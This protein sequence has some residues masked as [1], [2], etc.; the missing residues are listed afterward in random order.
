[1][2]AVESGPTSQADPIDRYIDTVQA[3]LEHVR[4]QK[5][6]IGRAAEACAESIARDG[7]AFS[8]GTGHGSFA[9]LEMF[10]RTG[11]IV[12]FRP[13]VETSMLTFHH[14]WG[15][16]G[17][18]QY[19]FIH[20]QEGFGRAILRAHR[21]K[22]GDALIL[23]SH[24]GLN[25]VILEMAIGA[26]AQGLTVVGI[27][28]LPHSAQSPSR[29][30]SGKRLFEVADVVIDTGVPKSDADLRI[31]GLEHPVGATSTSI[32]AAIAHA[33]VAKTAEALVARGRTPHV[34][35]NPNTAEREAANAINDR[36]YEELWRLMCAR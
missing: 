21:V 9:A 30:S 10:P 11:T 1:M 19:R 24:S 33:I 26:K 35:V 14:V 34:M 12:G 27:T 31:D 17:S 29:H 18:Y 7:L 15:D 6:A 36:N 25:A 8:F 23:L 16:T 32:A 20:T 5:E 2:S 13:I 3:R 28:S 22:A 4:T